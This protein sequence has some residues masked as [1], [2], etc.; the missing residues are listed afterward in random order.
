M[1]QPAK[2]NRPGGLP[3]GGGEPVAAHTTAAAATRED[4][5]PPNRNPAGAAPISINPFSRG[6]RAQRA[7]TVQPRKGSGWVYWPFRVVVS[8]AGVLLFNQAVFAGQF[9]AGTFGALHTHRENA[10][11]AGIV[12]LAAALAAVPIRWPGR[13]P[14]WPVFACLGLFGLIAL[15]I[16][17]GFARAL[18]LHVPLGVAIILLAV[19]LV[20]WAWRPHRVPAEPTAG[21]PTADP[22]A[23]APKGRP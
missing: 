18:T 20:I 12:V 8:A 22:T 15:Q 10:T 17:L 23:A 11:V 9:L 2:S 4:R 1:P 6:A 5:W 19:L 13:G 16:M 3:T 21:Q 7:S 14:S